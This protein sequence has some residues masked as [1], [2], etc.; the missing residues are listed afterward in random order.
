[1]R[2]KFIGNK[3]LFR[4]MYRKGLTQKELAAQ[5]KVSEGTLSNLLKNKTVNSKTSKKICDLLNKE[6]DELFLFDERED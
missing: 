2:L 1:M 4:E 3:V 6:F 5:L